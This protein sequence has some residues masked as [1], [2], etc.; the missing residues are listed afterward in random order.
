[1]I[2]NAQRESLFN[3]VDQPSPS[4]EMRT[5][6]WAERRDRRRVI[7]RIANDCLNDGYQKGSGL[8]RQVLKRYRQ[9]V[10]FDITMII[11]IV[12]LIVNVVRLVIQWRQKNKQWFPALIACLLLCLPLSAAEPELTVESLTINQMRYV[13]LAPVPELADT[14]AYQHGICAL[15]YPKPGQDIG[16]LVNDVIADMEKRFKPWGKYIILPPGYWDLRTPIILDQDVAGAHVVL[17]GHGYINTTLAMPFG[18]DWHFIGIDARNSREL[19]IRD[20]RVTEKVGD[21]VD[22]CCGIAIGGTSGKITD[23]WFGNSKIGCLVMGAG[24]TLRGNYSEFCRDGVLVTTRYFDSS[25]GIKA[26]T[27]NARDCTIDTQY[28]YRAPLTLRN[29]VQLTVDVTEGEVKA[30]DTL[31]YAGIE[32]P[33]LDVEDGKILLVNKTDAVS[34]TGTP[35]YLGDFRTSGGAVGMITRKGSNNLSNINVSLMTNQD[36][37]NGQP[38]VTVEGTEFVTMRVKSNGTHGSRL[39]NNTFLEF[40][41]SAKNPTSATRVENCQG[42]PLRFQDQKFAVEY[43]GANDLVDN[44]RTPQGVVE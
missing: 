42:L 17:R 25:L 11:G 20:L 44:V 32:V 16:Q 15:P 10:G 3:A 7:A 28:N 21:P 19:H 34:K 37:D 18:K 2:S 41:G 23:C 38:A 24:I 9:E 35:I 1:M 29:Y 13:P 6:V 43:S 39:R 36:N 14:E 30:G 26:A 12:S 31:Y 4:V 22:R 40:G 5:S 33:I 8:R 27:S